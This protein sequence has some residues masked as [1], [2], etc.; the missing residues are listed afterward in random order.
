MGVKVELK[1]NEFTALAGHLLFEKRDKD[2]PGSFFKKVRKVSCKFDDRYFDK[3]AKK[4]CLEL[5]PQ[6]AD[7]NS[8]CLAVGGE[9]QIPK[10]TWGKLEKIK[11]SRYCIWV[12][13][14]VKVYSPVD[15]YLPTETWWS[16]YSLRS[17][18][19][20]HVGHACAANLTDDALKDM[21]RCVREAYKK[22]GVHELSIAEEVYKK[23]GDIETSMLNLDNNIYNLLFCC[24]RL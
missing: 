22:L 2:K 10:I 15:V 14:W 4:N 11:G 18:R 17:L 5:I 6:P 12:P 9:V 19:N 20:T 24:F 8:F 7:K 13:L 16:V 3:I 1:D 21:F 23:L